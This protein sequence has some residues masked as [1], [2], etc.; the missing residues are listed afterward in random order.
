MSAHKK[1]QISG[2]YFENCNCDVVCPCLVST[3][4]PLTAKPSEGHC[5]VAI[6]FHIDRGTYDGV[7]LDGLNVALIGYAPGPMADGNMTLAAYIDERADDRQA[8]ALGAIFGGAEGGPMA[9]FAPLV[10]QHL[11]VRKVPIRYAIDGKN[12][13]AE[14]PGVMRMT[15]APIPTMHES[16]EAWIAAGHPIAPD[17]MAL[18]VGLPGNS[19]TDHGMVWDNSGKNGHYAP[20]A[21]S[22]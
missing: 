17:R 10:G 12:R 13:S 15:V 7:A 3:A 2:D 1:W 6:A 5:D 20:I 14:I 18:A 8:E 4:A 16:G 19:Y 22:G 11:G 21:W 9:A